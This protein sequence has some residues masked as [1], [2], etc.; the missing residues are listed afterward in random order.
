MVYGSCQIFTVLSLPAEARV[1]PS[2]LK[3]TVKTLLVWPLKVRIAL[4]F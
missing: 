1:L 2:G 3:V 4:P